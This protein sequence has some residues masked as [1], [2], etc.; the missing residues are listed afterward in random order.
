MANY[1]IISSD[2]HIFEPPDLW[3]TR[4][5]PKYRDRCPRIVRHDDGSDWWYCDG[6]I[7]PGTGFGFGGAQTGK[8]FEEGGGQNLTI[9]DT[10]E[11]VRPGGYIPE[12]QIK[13]MDIDG[14]DVSIV[15]P[16]V[17]LQL[18]KQPDG[19]LLSAIFSAY[20]DWVAEFC[21]VEPK[22]LKGIA[23]INVD[24][25][26]VGVKELERCAK[27]GFIGGMIT[28]QPPL[29]RRYNSPEYEPLWAAANDLGMP[30]SLHLE[31][32]RKGSG[33]ADGSLQD[34]LRPSIVTNCD[35]YVRMSLSDIIY[36]GVFERYPKLQVGAVEFEV[37]WAAHFIKSMDYNYTQRS[38]E[39]F[40]YQFKGDALPSDFFHSNIFVGFQEDDLGIRLRDIIGVN[41]LM[42]GSDYPHQESTFPRSRQIIEEVLSDCAEEEREKIAGGNA[43]RVYKI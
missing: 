33:E 17:G 38:H 21:S 13:D 30:L 1:R 18:F 28:V 15:Y 42:W 35:H 2:N 26:Q 43:A 20:N 37:S 29:G 6:N 10:F 39:I 32:N 24:D 36:A 41:N 22:R 27:V 11:N 8:R 12:E 34:D 14:V 4:I 31:T 25:V 9:G 23:V 7:I 3:A 5:E 16:T 40:Q 19:V